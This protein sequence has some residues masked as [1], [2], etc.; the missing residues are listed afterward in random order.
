MSVSIIGCGHWGKNLVRNF[1]GL[2]A[3][4]SICDPNMELTAQLSSLYDVPALSFED[5]LDSDCEGV[6][7][8]APAPLHASLAEKAFAAGK[9]AYVEKPLA[10]TLKEADRI[11]IAAKKADRQ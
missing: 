9:H 4:H 1:A 11:I 5:T 6:V 2:G 3:L 8:A 10:M 7:I